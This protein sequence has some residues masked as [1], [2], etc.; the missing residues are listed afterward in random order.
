MVLAEL[1]EQAQFNSSKVI[2]RTAVEEFG[3][4]AAKDKEISSFCIK[5]LLRLL[6]ECHNRDEVVASAVG[7]LRRLL[8]SDDGP[9]KAIIISRLASLLFS[10]APKKG[11]TKKLKLVGKGAV[12]S[13]L[14]RSSIYW[15][16]GQYC[17][18]EVQ[19][20]RKGQAEGESHSSTLA[21]IIGADVL[22]R[23]A[24]NFTKEEIS[25]KL[26][27]LVLSTKLN[28]FLPTVE[29]ENIKTVK[30]IHSYILQ[31]ARYDEDFDVRDRGR[32]CKALTDRVEAHVSKEGQPMKEQE[33]D[34]GGQLGG[35]ILRRDQVLHILFEGKPIATVDEDSRARQK[36]EY[37]LD[38]LSYV[39]KGSKIVLDKKM[40]FSIPWAEV[41]D[42]P[43]ISVREPALSVSS[44]LSSKPSLLSINSQ[45]SFSNDVVSGVVKSESLTA[46]KADVSN[47]T[48]SSPGLPTPI[49]SK[50]KDLDA[51]LDEESEEDE[52]SEVLEEGD[53]GEEEEDDDISANSS[54][55]ESNEMESEESDEKEVTTRLIPAAPIEENEWAR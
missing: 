42:L 46:T 29:F 51:F 25:A 39:M 53:E 20:R 54:E 45:R 40:D 12:K 21:Q 17:R 35:V 7:V 43:P 34:E 52:E 5:E 44:S 23:A 55:E 6:K 15:L 50:Y 37:N 2:S 18:L 9:P 1:S 4:L 36:E 47:S 33:N 13:G 49:A 22:R 16:L 38:A 31:L 10:P 32:F 8:Q 19:V 14:A 24:S 26:Q 48:A 27:I 28:I 41:K 11:S 3:V 30:L